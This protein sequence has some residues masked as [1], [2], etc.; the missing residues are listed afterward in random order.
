MKVDS[1]DPVFQIQ[2]SLKPVVMESPITN[3]EIS[4]RGRYICGWTENQIVFVYNTNTGN[5][6]CFKA[7]QLPVH[8]EISERDSSLALIYRNNNVSVCN[9]NGKKQYNFETTLNKVINDKL[10]CFF[11]SGKAHVAAV[12][13]NTVFLY[14][15]AGRRIGELNGHKGNINSID[16]SPD[17]NYLV[18][19]SDDKQAYIWYNSRRMNRYAIYDTL[20]GHNAKIWSCRFNKTGKYI[21]T[22]SEDSMIKI[23][24]MNGRQINPQFK[25]IAGGNHYRHNNREP[26]EDASNPYFSKYYG[27]FCDA[28]FSPWEM[29]IIAT[30]FKIESDSLVNNK[31][32]YYKVMF[33]D[34]SP[35]FL[36]A[37]GRRYYLSPVGQEVFKPMTFSDLRISP[38]ETIVAAVDSISSQIYILTG[39]NFI[40]ESF[41]GNNPMFSNKGD[42]LY[43]ISEKKIC[44]TIISPRKIR[45]L[46]EKIIIKGRS[47][48]TSLIQI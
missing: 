6:S 7:G 45:Q 47:G 29:E 48:E 8:L 34:G 37:Y 9:F 25:I 4:G 31:N 38:D 27:K 16:I 23:W 40:L 12:K 46:I 13:G 2:N 42:V 14:D 33:F 32:N 43:W 41:S 22:A 3:A 44:K 18:T 11:P 28:E 39:N 26:D 30:G 1:S 20:S 5:L 35:G 36:Q 10:V 17:G 19:A 21:I 15:R 24:D